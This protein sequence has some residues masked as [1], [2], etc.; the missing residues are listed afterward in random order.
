[1][2][3]A[4]SKTTFVYAILHFGATLCPACC[5]RQGANRQHVP[6]THMPYCQS[7]CKPKRKLHLG[8][9]TIAVH[10]VQL[11]MCP[12]RLHSEA[13]EKC[14]KWEAGCDS[15]EPQTS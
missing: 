1:M 15:P 3:A 4:S 11:C 14:T 5:L 9:H 6:H 7:C 2:A 13:R 8:S 10:S 12:M